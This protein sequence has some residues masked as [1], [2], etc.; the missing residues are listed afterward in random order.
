MLRRQKTDMINGKAL[1]DLPQKHINVVKCDFDKEESE[2]YLALEGKIEEVVNKFMKSGDAGRKY[3]AALLLL[4]RLRQ[5]ELY[6]F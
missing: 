6:T 5:G 4:L 3:T 2:F 1:I